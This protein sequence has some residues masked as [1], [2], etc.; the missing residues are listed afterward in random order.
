MKIGNDYNSG[1]RK[2]E[3]RKMRGCKETKVINYSRYFPSI[4]F[5]LHIIIF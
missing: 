5:P 3:K 4:S 2:K 1:E